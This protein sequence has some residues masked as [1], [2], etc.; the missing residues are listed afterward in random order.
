MKERDISFGFSQSFV[1]MLS[2]LDGLNDNGGEEE[3][4]KAVKK[5]TAK[6]ILRSLVEA[7]RN[8]FYSIN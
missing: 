3:I 5:T 4:F 7:N 6:R 2:S 1:G 8:S